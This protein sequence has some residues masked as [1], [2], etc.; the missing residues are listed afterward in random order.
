MYDFLGL[1]VLLFIIW[2]QPSLSSYLGAS[3]AIAL[4]MISWHIERVDFWF[5]S[6]GC[7]FFC[8]TFAHCYDLL[9]DRFLHD[10]YRIMPVETPCCI[11]HLCCTH[12]DKIMA[13]TCV[14]RVLAGLSSI[15]SCYVS[16][17]YHEKFWRGDS[18]VVIGIWVATVSIWLVSCIPHF[19]CLIQCA[20]SNNSA[21][22]YRF[23]KYVAMWLIHDI[24]LGIFWLYLALMLDHLL[25]DD[26]SEWRTIF[27]SMISWHIVIFVI[28][29][30][31]FSELWSITEQTTC[32]GPKTRSRWGVIMQLVCMIVIYGVVVHI[33]RDSVDMH[34]LDILLVILF[35]CALVA[36]YLGKL[37][38]LFPQKLKK[39]TDVVFAV[40]TLE[41][42]NTF[43]LD[44]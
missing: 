13:I 34:A 10:A 26:D 7:A 5:L 17:S 11:P 38:T 2:K 43:D 8:M 9:H 42:R 16:W 30:L 18:D 25:K 41:R 12:R 33:V 23:R 27:L 3:I 31:Y 6:L 40:R 35:I 44:F 28:R 1:G 14:F 29:Q 20:A 24:V 21:E 15:S 36:G 4:A 22:M 39:K 37:L 32:C 19:I